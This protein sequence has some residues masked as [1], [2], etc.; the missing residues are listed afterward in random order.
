MATNVYN[1][2]LLSLMQNVDGPNHDRFMLRAGQWP[3]GVLSCTMS[4]PDQC[5][6]AANYIYNLAQEAGIHEQTFYE[7]LDHLSRLQSLAEFTMVFDSSTVKWFETYNMPVP[8][9]C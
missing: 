5:A 9:G 8:G 7:Q 4:E 6:A 3:D 1:A 2:M